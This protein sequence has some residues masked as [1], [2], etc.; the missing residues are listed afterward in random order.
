MRGLEVFQWIGGRTQTILV[1]YDDKFVTGGFELQQGRDNTFDQL[2]FL[3]TVYLKIFRLNDQGSVTIQK[4]NP[5]LVGT[6]A[7]SP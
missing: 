3:Q 2:K 6:H 1:A 5:A 4:Q 7:C